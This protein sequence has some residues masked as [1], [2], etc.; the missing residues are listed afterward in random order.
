MF[1]KFFKETNKKVDI[2]FDIDSLK[3]AKKEISTKLDEKE[4]KAL[5]LYNDAIVKIQLFSALGKE[6]DLKD[7]SLLL[8]ESLKYKQTSDSL[9]W[10]A[11]IFYMFG[12]DDLCIQFL[13]ASEQ[14]EPNTAR[15]IDFKKKFNL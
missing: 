15:V 12:K 4:E 5:K 7:A 3:N 11:F 1:K 8:E 10:L 13:K 14:L 9:F 2:G 6:K